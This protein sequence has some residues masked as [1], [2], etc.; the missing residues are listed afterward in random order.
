MELCEQEDL[1]RCW[2][3]E[4]AAAAGR[5]AAIRGTSAA[6][7]R[8]GV[9]EVAAQT[10]LAEGYEESLSRYRAEEAQLQKAELN[11]RPHAAAQEQGDIGDME[12]LLRSRDRL[13]LEIKELEGAQSTRG[14]AVSILEEKL[15]L[16]LE[17]ALQALQQSHAR[18]SMLE[19]DV[20]QKGKAHKLA[21]KQDSFQWGRRNI[22]SPPS[23][24]GCAEMSGE[25][26]SV[27]KAP[28]GLSDMENTTTL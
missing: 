25:D 2:N 24:E 11:L 18:L 6:Q 15:Q 17:Q 13:R 19:T 22:G 26:C 1:A 7:A 3:L 5:L 23:Q 20:E 28:H 27:Q 14:G 21:Q 9:E 16:G 12:H 4:T 10:C 8:A